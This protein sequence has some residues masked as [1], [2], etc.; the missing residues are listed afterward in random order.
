MKK[1][2]F[3]FALILIF[4]TAMA[5][6]VEPLKSTG[7][8][9]DLKEKTKG[10]VV[11][12]NFWATWCKPCVTEFPELVKLYNDYK[13]RG[14]ELVFISLDMPEEVK[15]KLIPFLEKNNVDF[16]S[17]Y[18]DFK[19]VSDLMNYFDKKWEGAIPSTYIYDRKGNLATGF[20]GSRNYEFFEKE[21]LKHLD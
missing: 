13:S 8:L 12:Y 14:F 7:D 3:I 9:D 18:N 20:I 15:T 17:Y 19:D 2:I 16:L 21:I 5:Q 4:R 6:N 11:L 10:K 1:L